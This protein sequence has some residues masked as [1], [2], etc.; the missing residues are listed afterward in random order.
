MTPDSKNTESLPYAVLRSRDLAEF[1]GTTP[2]A[3]RHYHNIGLL[4]EV[5]RDPNGYRSY[6]THDLVRVLHIRQ[7]AA[8]GMPLRKIGAVLE[9]DVQDQEALLAALDRD[10]EAQA[11]RIATQRKMLAELRQLSIRSGPFSLAEGSSATQQFDQDVWTLIT[12][13]GE[14]NA[15]TAEALLAAVQSESVSEQAAPWYREFEQLEGQVTVDHAHAEQLAEQ[16]SDFAHTVMETAG[17]VPAD[18]ELPIMALVEQ[19]HVE[20]L[21]PAQQKVF[22]LLLALL[23]KQWDEHRQS[24][25]KGNA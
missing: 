4:P 10:L 15:E 3:L 22:G 2:R 13:T 6:T 20:A 7:L 5:P 12:A 9:Q 21:S 14:V 19:M 24:E 18:E 23:E 8:S 1:A 25:D 17:I 16:I 11:E